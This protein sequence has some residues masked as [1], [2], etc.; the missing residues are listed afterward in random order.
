MQN[1]VYM[2]REAWVNLLDKIRAKAGIADDLTAETAADAVEGIQTGGGDSIEDWLLTGVDMP[3]AYINNHISQIR[4]YCFYQNKTL[5]SISGASVESVGTETFS[6]CSNLNSI[7]FPVVK[8]LNAS[9]CLKCSNLKSVYCPELTAV[10]ANVFDACSNL[11]DVYAPKVETV[12]GYSFRSCTMLSKLDLPMLVSISTTGFFGSGL[13][14]LILRSETL[15]TMSGV[16]ALKSTPIASGT[17]YIY[18]PRA[19]LSD[20]DATKDYR[21]ATNWSTYANQFRALEDYTVDG[22][23]TG[24]LDETKI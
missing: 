13:D 12:A 14:T 5:K 15:C 9:A 11:T 8:N 23:T 7:S 3:E 19:L 24:E 10:K 17:G 18:V 21:R 16:N 1:I 6:N 2:T 4:D 20:D 22:T